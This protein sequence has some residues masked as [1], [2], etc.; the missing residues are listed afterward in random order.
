MQGVEWVQISER[1]TLHAKVWRQEGPWLAVAQCFLGSRS[2]LLN[3]DTWGCLHPHPPPPGF[4][5][6][7]PQGRGQGTDLNYYPVPRVILVTG[8]FGKHWELGWESWIEP[9]VNGLESHKES[10]PPQ[11]GFFYL[12]EATESFKNFM[13]LISLF[14]ENSPPLP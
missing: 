8:K 1:T 6:Q 14:P 12:G 3:T 5:N 9:R 7:N 11:A 2:S 10:E 4:L 13:K